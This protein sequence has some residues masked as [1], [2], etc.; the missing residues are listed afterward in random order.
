M[1]GKYKLIHGNHMRYED[2]HR[3][4]YGP[5]DV[6]EP[7]EAELKA[8]GDKLELVHQET[9]KETDTELEILRERARELNIPNAHKMGKD[10]LNKE[11]AEK[12][13][14]KNGEQ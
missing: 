11:I 10:R 13:N 8:F 7:T 2:G 1:S 5:G 3:V 6:F 9:K 12:E 14:D 4:V